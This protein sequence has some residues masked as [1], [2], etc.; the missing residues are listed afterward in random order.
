MR[1]RTRKQEQFQKVS[2]EKTEGK[3]ALKLRSL[4][5]SRDQD[6]GF[7]NARFK[8]EEVEKP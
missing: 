8:T 1:K 3:V 7:D 4:T 2:L 5:E 6:R